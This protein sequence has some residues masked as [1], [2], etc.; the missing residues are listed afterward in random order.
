MARRRWRR[1]K[2]VRL[3]RTRRL[4]GEESMPRDPTRSYFAG[5]DRDRAAFEA[6]LQP[7]SILNPFLGGPLAAG[8]VATVEPVDGEG[9]CLPTPVRGRPRA[10]GAERHRVLGPL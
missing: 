8:K 5:T 1:G 6:G 2:P 9:A 7:G 4:A 10:I 3:S